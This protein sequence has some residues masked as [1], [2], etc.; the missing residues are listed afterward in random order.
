MSQHTPPGQMAPHIPA[1]VFQRAQATGQPVVIVVNDTTPPGFPWQRVL[2]PFAIAGAVVA[3]GW[4]LA[5]ALCWLL[6]V[7]T[8]TATAIAG[9]TAGP[10]GVGGITLK[11][12]QPKNK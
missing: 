5:A 6:D 7:A 2:I 11:L 1:D 9:A 10:L 4:G 12:F 3:G 8:H